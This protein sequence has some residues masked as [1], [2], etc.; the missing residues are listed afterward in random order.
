MPPGPVEAKWICPGRGAL[1]LCL[2]PCYPHPCPA[3]VQAQ[4]HPG[5]A[6]DVT[7]P[8]AA[9]FKADSSASQTC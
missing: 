4:A 1:P 2:D 8:S 9:A 5:A 6:G 7:L 3:A